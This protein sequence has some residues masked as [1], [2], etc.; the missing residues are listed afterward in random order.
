MYSADFITINKQNISYYEIKSIF[1]NKFFIFDIVN[2]SHQILENNYYFI[3]PD[4]QLKNT[5]ECI[6]QTA[7][8]SKK[9][10]KCVFKLETWETY[11]VLNLFENGQSFYEINRDYSDINYWDEEVMKKDPVNIKRQQYLKLEKD[12]GP[13]LSSHIKKIFPKVSFEEKIINFDYPSGFDTSELENKIN[14]PEEYYTTYNSIIDKSF[15][16]TDYLKK[17]CKIIHSEK[18]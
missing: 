1:K 16:K 4:D 8:L 13:L 7:L 18:I 12:K 6:D 5:H 11:F 15:I 9:F 10:N 2:N 17:N 14:I 3:Y